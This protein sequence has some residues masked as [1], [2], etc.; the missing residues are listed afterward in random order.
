MKLFS[1]LVVLAMSF[2]AASSVSAAAWE[3]FESATPPAIPAGSY[4]FHDTGEQAEATVAGGPG[5]NY[6]RLNGTD[7]NSNWYLGGWGN[8]KPQDW[9]GMT[10]LQANVKGDGSYGT[11]KYELYENDGDV[12]AGGYYGSSAYIPIDWTGWKAVSI[13]FADLVD[14]NPGVGSDTWTGD[15]KQ[16]NFVTACGGTGPGGSIDIGID[17]IRAVPEPASLLLFGSGL[18]GM[19]AASRRKK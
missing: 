11:I 2:F 16:I 15:L 4:S 13:P 17:D 3:D 7:L 10:G 9:S 1:A 14:Q 18:A 5:G 6:L 12:F 19:F 8:Y